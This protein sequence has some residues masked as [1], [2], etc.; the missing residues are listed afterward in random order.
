MTTLSVPA[1]GTLSLVRKGIYMVEAKC[2][3]AGLRRAPYNS[4]YFSVDTIGTPSQIGSTLTII[5][6]VHEVFE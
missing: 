2:L 1:G 5:Y 3:W 4:A 6:F